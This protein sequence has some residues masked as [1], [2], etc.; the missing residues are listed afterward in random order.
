MKT[1]SLLWIAGAL[2]LA[3]VGQ[4][5]YRNYQL[6]KDFDANL[7]GLSYKGQQDGKT[8]FNCTVN[9]LN[10]SN[11]D[12][13]IKDVQGK[14][15]VNGVQVGSFSKMGEQVIASDAYIDINFDFTLDDKSIISQWNV[16][17]G[18]ILQKK[19]LPLD[20]VGVFRYKTIFGYLT[21][22]LRISTSGRDLY[23]TWK[24]YYGPGAVKKS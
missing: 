1:K 18:T 5:Y 24:E 14:V 11:L 21:I 8:V 3:G 7:K 19:D 10:K 2:A 20:I 4:Y 16:V 23:A 22:P 13:T 6:V 17:L 9:I 12:A 15:L